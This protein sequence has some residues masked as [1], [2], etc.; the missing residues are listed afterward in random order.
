M[1]QA[2]AIIKLQKLNHLDITIAPHNSLNFSRGFILPE[3]FLNVSTEEILE[4]MKAQKVCRIRRITKRRDGQELNTK[5]LILTF[6]TPDL[7]QT[8]KMGYIRCSYRHYL[9]NPL[10]SLTVHIKPAALFSM[11]AIQPLKKCLLRPVQFPSLRGIR[12]RQC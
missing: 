5:N 2:K 12:S 10:P 11:P 7:S 8:V 3:D 9:P 1:N 4:N 6:S